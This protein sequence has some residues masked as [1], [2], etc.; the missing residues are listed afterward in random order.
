MVSG[1]EFGA[2]YVELLD[3]RFGEQRAGLLAESYRNRAGQVGVTSGVI[4]EHVE[5]PERGRPEADREPR[6][7]RLLV[8]AESPGE[9]ADDD[10]RVVPPQVAGRTVGRGRRVRSRRRSART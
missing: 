4:G 9:L 3:R 2:Q 1:G 5:D 7:G 6:D 10:L 8:L